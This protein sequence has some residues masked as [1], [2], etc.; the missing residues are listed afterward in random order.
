MIRSARAAEEGLGS[1]PA[2]R[3]AVGV[4]ENEIESDEKL[5][6]WPQSY[7]AEPEQRHSRLGIERPADPAQ[8]PLRRRAPLDRA[9]GRAKTRA[10]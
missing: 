4:C 8:R 2:Q 5:S 7:H 1:A 9:P 6:S 3:R 10:K